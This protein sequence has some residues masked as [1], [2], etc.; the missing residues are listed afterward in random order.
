VQRAIAEQ[1]MIDRLGG[2]D[3]LLNMVNLI[4]PKRFGLMPNQPYVR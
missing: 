2:I 4:G 1:M 3:E